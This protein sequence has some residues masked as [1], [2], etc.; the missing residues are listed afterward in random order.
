MYDLAIFMD[1]GKEVRA[2]LG[3]V[4]KDS[5]NLV[6]A[7]NQIARI[8]W[9]AEADQFDT[10]G[11]RGGVP[12]EDLKEPYR[13]RKSKTFPGR[14]IL[15]A[16]GLMRASLMG[17]NSNAVFSVSPTQMKI[18][19]SVPY[20]RFH[21][22]GTRKMARRPVIMMTEDDA[23]EFARQIQLHIMKGLSKEERAA[24]KVFM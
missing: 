23:K 22:S 10:E 11:A 12:W 1:G 20:A 21:Q 7:F 13:S 2:K 6:P 9:R 18:G 4:I 15:V 5:D 8:F 3:F 16:T 14:P 17:G 19:T 24:R